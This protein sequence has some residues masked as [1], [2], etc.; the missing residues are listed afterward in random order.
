MLYQ[1]IDSGLDHYVQLLSFE[2]SVLPL[3]SSLDPGH[4]PRG[5][6]LLQ[7]ALQMQRSAEQNALP[8]NEKSVLFDCTTLPVEY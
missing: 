7:I 8:A 5:V 2:C 1:V 4:V 3:I 6:L